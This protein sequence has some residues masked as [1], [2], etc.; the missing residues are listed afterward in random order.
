MARTPGF[1][2]AWKQIWGPEAFLEEMSAGAVVW[3]SGHWG[4]MSR[5]GGQLDRDL[6][7]EVAQAKGLCP[8]WG[9]PGWAWPLSAFLALRF[10][11]V[12]YPLSGPSILFLF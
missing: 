11:F 8:G 4:K 6:G 3:R 2:K 9:G 7:C 10:C 5:W 1:Q 12:V